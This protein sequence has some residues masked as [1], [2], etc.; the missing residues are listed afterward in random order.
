MLRLAET[1]APLRSTKAALVISAVAPCVPYPGNRKIDCGKRWRR[2]AIVCG[3]VAD[4]LVLIERRIAQGRGGVRAAGRA[5]VAALHVADHEQAEFLRLLDQAVVRLDAF[6]EIF[7]EVRRL[8][9]HAG[10]D[11]RDDLQHLDD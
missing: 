2:V 3:W 6:P 11:R 9:L 5:D 4:G 7:F 1:I 8:E 10:D